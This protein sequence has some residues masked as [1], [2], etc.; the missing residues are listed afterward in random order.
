MAL[1]MHDT[2]VYNVF[3]VSDA[4]VYQCLVI[5]KAG[6]DRILFELDVHGQYFNVFRCIPCSTI[7]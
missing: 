3:Q 7:I 1:V 2:F 5:N 4:A 6:E